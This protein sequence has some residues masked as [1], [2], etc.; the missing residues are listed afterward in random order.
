[1]AEIEVV[2][3]RSGNGPAVVLQAS[4]L[5]VETRLFF[6]GGVASRRS[7]TH[8]RDPGRT[9]LRLV[10]LVRRIGR[11]GDD[12]DYRS[13]TVDR[14]PVGNRGGPHVRARDLHDPLLGPLRRTRQTPDGPIVVH[15]EEDVSTFEV[16]EGGDLACQPFRPDVVA[17][18][19]DARALAVPHQLRQFRL[20][21]R[22]LPASDAPGSRTDCRAAGRLGAA[23]HPPHSTAPVGGERVDPTPAPLRQL[24]PPHRRRTK[25]SAGRMSM[26][27]SVR[28][29]RG[30]RHTT[31]RRPTRRRSR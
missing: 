1:M 11:Q 12:A 7:D 15:A 31:T 30:S 17:L 19:L 5:H 23:R 28:R 24:A 25:A 26:P 4:R 18:E 2:E 6:I 14:L 22:T 20:V 10:R 21:H 13:L 3:R 16:E 27:S 9:A 29:A 8:L